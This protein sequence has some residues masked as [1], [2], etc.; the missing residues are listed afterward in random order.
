[1]PKVKGYNELNICSCHVFE[2]MMMSQ[3]RGGD[4]ALLL[5]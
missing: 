3:E 5:G 4:V 2:S 1:M